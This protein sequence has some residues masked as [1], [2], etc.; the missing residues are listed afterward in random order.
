VSTALYASRKPERVRRLVMYAGGASQGPGANA[1]VQDAWIISTRENIMARI[2][3]DVIVPEAQEAFIT[4]AL[5]WDLRSPVSGRR[6]TAPDG[7][8]WRA[9]PEQISVP[10]LVIY[11]ARDPGYR[12]DE[13]A[14][15]VAR[16]NTSDKALVVVPGA[17]HSLIMQTMRLR[18]FSTAEQ[19]FSYA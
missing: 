14:S 1:A 5:R 3:Q 16:L 11:G 4:A 13:V 2:E 6:L 9:A 7:K 12:A 17:G 19:W 8:P 15:F 18:L 10:T